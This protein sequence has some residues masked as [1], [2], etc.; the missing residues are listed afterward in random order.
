MV[1]CGWEL[2]I[3]IDIDI[4][5]TLFNKLKRMTRDKIDCSIQVDLALSILQQLFGSISSS[6]NVK[7]EN[8]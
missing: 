7:F 5:Q 8:I 6:K 3:D 2:G 4:E 1:W